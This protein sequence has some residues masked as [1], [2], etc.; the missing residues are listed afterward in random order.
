MD[1]YLKQKGLIITDW[2]YCL[3]LDS[4]DRK[5][6]PG[7]I[8]SAQKKYDIDLSKSF[9]IGDKATDVFETDG[10]FQRPVTFLVRGRYD[11]HHPDVG[12][13]VY[14]YDNHKAILAELKTRL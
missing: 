3:E 14:V 9:M 11:L 7:M 10:K 1:D 2:F 12:N 8:L 13:G 5:P 6:R 4:E